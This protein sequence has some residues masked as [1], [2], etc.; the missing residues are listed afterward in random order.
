[1]KKINV[2][3]LIWFIILT[4]FTVY[5]YMLIST[6]KINTFIHPKMLSYVYFSLGVFALL[7]VFQLKK[8]FRKSYSKSIKPG[9]LIFLAPLILGFA[10]NPG[11]LNS[12]IIGKKGITISQNNSIAQAQQANDNISE[13][14]FENNTTAR[15]NEDKFNF[16]EVRIEINE[17]NFVMETDDIYLNAEALQGK[18]VSISG[19]VYT[20]E[21]F[22]QNQFVTARM[23]MACCAADTEVIGL[24]CQVDEGSMPKKDQWIKVTGKLF[25]TKHVQTYTQEE[26]EI[27]AILVDNIESIP[28]PEIP[29][30]Y[31]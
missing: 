14:T 19:F 2:N 30:V 24:L 27:P 6:G 21:G 15:S 9:F 31:P 22:K 16:P 17:S 28:T 23:L 10:V 1:M 7:S 3:E 18:E 29:Y 26:I 11:G 12:D 25:M 20:D 4:G 8:I 5:L 13:S